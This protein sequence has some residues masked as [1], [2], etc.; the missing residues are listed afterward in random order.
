MVGRLKDKEILARQMKLE[1]NRYII[2]T[3]TKS[4]EQSLSP[5]KTNPGLG[6]KPV[7]SPNKSNSH[8]TGSGFKPRP[9]QVT[10]NLRSIY[11]TITMSQAISAPAFKH[12]KTL[13]CFCFSI[14]IVAIIKK[15]MC[16]I[17][18]RKKEIENCIKSYQI[19]N[20]WRC[21]LFNT[22]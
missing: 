14:I 20:I 2:N 10:F 6:L 4:A 8:E 16:T 12:I 7:Y 11:L 22:Q 3:L 15:K 17:S 18:L 13:D 21:H 9:C 5:Y 19:S 1:L